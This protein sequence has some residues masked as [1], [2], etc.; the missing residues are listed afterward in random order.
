MIRGLELGSKLGFPTANLKVAT[1]HK[2][3]P[4]NGVF[5]AYVW[6]K[7][8]RYQSMFYIGNRM[9]IEGHPQLTMEA[10]IFDFDDTIYGEDIHCLLYT[11][12]SPRD[13][14]LSRMPSSA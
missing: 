14:T 1:K 13:A 5:A 4:P 7:N 11:S 3:I 8:Q 10:N 2:L 12:P 9:T 6:Y